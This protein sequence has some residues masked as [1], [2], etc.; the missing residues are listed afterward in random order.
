VTFNPKSPED[1]SGCQKY[2]AALS[3][4]NRRGFLLGAAAMVTSSDCNAMSNSVVAGAIRWDAWYDPRD[5]SVFAQRSLSWEQ[6]E[7]R[8][9]AHC[10]VAADHK[11]T[12][13]GT[14]ETLD[15]EIRE[16]ASSGLKYW[17]FVWYGPNSSFRTAWN[18]YQSSSLRH[19][20]GWCGIVT[21]DLLGS[22]PFKNGEW[23]NRMKEWAGY[24]SQ[25]HYQK[26]TVNDAPVRPVLFL[27]WHPQDVK[28]YFADS[29]D[30]VRLALGYLRDLVK[31][32]GLDSPY[33]VILDGPEGASVTAEC[34][35]DAI[36]NYISGFRH[37]M[38][39]PYR[40]LDRQTRA[41]WRTLA[42]AGVPIVPIAMVGWDTRARRAHPVPWERSESTAPPNLRQ[43]YVLPEPAE[44]GAHLQAAVDYIGRNARACP[45]Q[46]L[47]IYSWDECDEGGGLIPTVE[48]PSG[49]YLSAIARVLR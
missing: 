45:S 46:L 23:R 41:Y 49:S 10:R 42:A 6:Y 44:L 39:G 36:S 21:L 37:E 5:N 2:F 26:V 30:N 8:A 48:D 14:Q 33:I 12:C 40:D 34:G 29:V 9:P 18:L 43:Y 7:G 16:A 20:V 24:M 27:L 13:V 47:L 19:M 11:V 35:A 3:N 15:K 25:P 4:M 31:E 17:A 28:N 1:L 22:L 32:S 38:V